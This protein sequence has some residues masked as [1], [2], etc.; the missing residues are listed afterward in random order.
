MGDQELPWKLRIPGDI[1]EE[2]E[3]EHE[4]EHTRSQGPAPPTTTALTTVTTTP[5]PQIATTPAITPNKDETNDNEAAHQQKAI[6]TIN[7][8]QSPIELP[9]PGQSGGKDEESSD[10]E[11]VMSST[12]YPGQEWRPAGFSG[13]EY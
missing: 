10:E 2:H 4:H 13:W 12:A 5:A 7:E 11:V 3:H 8:G 6:R 9:A 1:D